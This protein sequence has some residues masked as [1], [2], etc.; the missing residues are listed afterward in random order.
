ALPA[1]L[2]RQVEPTREARGQEAADLPEGEPVRIRSAVHAI[3]GE[4]D[5]AVRAEGDPVWRSVVRNAPERR[6]LERSRVNGNGRR[7]GGRAAEEEAC[8]Q[9]SDPHRDST[10]ACSAAWSVAGIAR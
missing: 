8:R 10:N 7:Q 5:L 6:K 3:L 9:E 4:A 2:P 1:A